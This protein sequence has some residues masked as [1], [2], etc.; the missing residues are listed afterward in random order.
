MVRLPAGQQAHRGRLG[1]AEVRELQYDDESVLGPELQVSNPAGGQWLRWLLLALLIASPASQTPLAR[2]RRTRRFRRPLGELREA[3][4]LD[5]EAIAERLIA[6]GI[7]SA[8]DVL[9]ALLEDRL[10]FRTDDQKSSSSRRPKAIRAA[11]SSSIRCR[12][13]TPAPAPPDSLT[14]IGTNN[15]LRRSVRTTLAHFGLS[16][17]DAAMRLAAIK[18]MLRSLDEPT[19]ALLRE[20]RALKQTRAFEGDRHRPRDGRSGRIGSRRAP[21]GHRDA[22]EPPQLRCSQQARR[23]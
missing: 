7:R 11:T 9:T 14:K 15:R 3:T 6:A 12:S 23:A 5:K 19:V 22:V 1:E 2:K 4:F 20:R 16:S 10:Y 17:P 21:R 13:R 8:R 18:D